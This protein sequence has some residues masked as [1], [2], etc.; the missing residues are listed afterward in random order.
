MVDGVT[1][2]SPKQ[3]KKRC[4]KWVVYHGR[5]VPWDEVPKECGGNDVIFECTSSK[6]HKK[7]LL[8]K[9][10]KKVQKHLDAVESILN[11]EY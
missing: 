11:G 9:K 5:I 4:K 1:C 6:K 10:L 7:K 3:K 8:K 2:K